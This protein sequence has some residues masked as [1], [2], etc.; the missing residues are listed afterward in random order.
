MRLDRSLITRA[1]PPGSMRYFAWLY[2]PSEQRD[3]IA[4]LFVIEAELYDSARARHEVAHHRLQWWRDEIDQL[5]VGKARHPAT[6]ALQTLAGKPIDFQPLHSTL[7]STTQE[8]AHATYETEAELSRYFQD[9]LGNL[10]ATAVHYLS[11]QPSVT[12]IDAAKQLGA[13]IRHC[14]VIR[15]MRP[16]L[17]QGRLFLPLAALDALHLDYEQLQ[18]DNWPETFVQL[19]HNRCVQALSEFKTLKQ[20][21][22]TDEKRTLRPLLV[23]AELHA[24]MLQTLSTDPAAY[25]QSRIELSPLRKLWIAWRA[26]RLAS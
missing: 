7:L 26:A 8:L 6:Q 3:V 25:T 13:F 24:V 12:L 19:L 17:R 15:D 9:G 22:L 4:A 21:L 10:L 18:S 14:E 16:D 5:K 11:N 1:L 23:L 2:T 20:S